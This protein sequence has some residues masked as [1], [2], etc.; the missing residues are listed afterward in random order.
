ML[1]NQLAENRNQC[2]E[3]FRL[4]EAAEVDLTT[5]KAKGVSVK[6]ELDEL[7]A[8]VRTAREER[9]RASR[10]SQDEVSTLCRDLAA[11][12]SHATRAITSF[13]KT[14]GHLYKVS[15]SL[16]SVQD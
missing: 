5:E 4:L 1:L 12:A 8:D 10:N 11:S 13:R 2:E 9:I 16:T 15:E 3:V 6:Q 7:K 14:K